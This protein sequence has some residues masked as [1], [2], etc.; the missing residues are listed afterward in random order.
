MCLTNTVDII[1]F[2][3]LDKP[4]I[5]Q[6]EH[7]KRKLLAR[8]EELQHRIAELDRGIQKLQTGL[9]KKTMA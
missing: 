1:A 5:E 6:L 4:Q 2:E 9:D 8:K 7:L 3:K